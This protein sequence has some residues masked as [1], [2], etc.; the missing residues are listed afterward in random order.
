MTKDTKLL[1]GRHKHNDPVLV[2]ALQAVT[3]CGVALGL[4]LYAVIVVRS[5]MAAS[6][7]RLV[8]AA[9]SGQV[10]ADAEMARIEAIAERAAPLIAATFEKNTSVADHRNVKVHIADMLSSTPVMAIAVLDGQ[11]RVQST[12]GQMPS[13]AVGQLA[14]ISTSQRA[15]QELI[16]LEILPISSLRAAYYREIPLADGG[17]MPLVFVLRTGAFRAALDVGASAGDGWRAA[18]LNLDG[19]VVRSNAAAGSAFAPSDASLAERAF[20]WSPLYSDQVSAPVRFSGRADGNF[21]EARSVAGGRLRLAYLGNEPSALTVLA[22]RKMEFAA[23]FGV[24]M[25]ALILA[26]SLIQ[27][28]WRRDDTESEDTFLVLAQARASCDLLDAGVIDWSLGDGRIVYSEGWAEIFA[29]GA[30]PVS[31][32]V[33]EWIS[34]I[35]PQDQEA[36]RDAYQSM[37]DGAENTIEHRIRVRLPSG[38]WVQVLERGRV[39]NGLDGRPARI[40]LVQTPE[41]ADGSALRETLNSL[42]PPKDYAVAG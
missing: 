38:L 37:L 26:L 34:R 29:R 42:N 36:A 23:L 9:A 25:L 20:G 33:H 4:I 5:E 31:G 22:S 6:Q 27:N 32:E 2:R 16:G 39:V 12:F 10:A 1:R 13:D 35:H 30:K 11:G 21:L 7:G 8:A 17:R 14:P 15:G 28:E 24:S 3:F 41:A 18:L 40:V 19:E